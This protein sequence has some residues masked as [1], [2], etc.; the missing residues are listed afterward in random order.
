MEIVKSEE[1]ACYLS[2]KLNVDVKK[3]SKLL[4]NY[5]AN[6]SS[7]SSSSPSPDEEDETEQ[8]EKKLLERAEILFRKSK[9]KKF[10]NKC[11][12]SFITAYKELSFDEIWEETTTQAD[13][14]FGDDIPC[15]NDDCWYQGNLDRIGGYE[16][17]YRNRFSEKDEYC[18]VCINNS[19]IDP[20]TT[21]F[22]IYAEFVEKMRT[23]FSSLK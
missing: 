13:L 17:S 12:N 11:F 18:D 10:S 21:D 7:K 1:L 22:D 8:I 9:D 19:R 6:Y 23:K 3:I 4:K 20:D 5:A 2:E 15:N 14:S 16:C